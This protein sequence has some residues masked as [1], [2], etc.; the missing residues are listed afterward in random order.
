MRSRARILDESGNARFAPRPGVAGHRARSRRPTAWRPGTLVPATAI[1]RRLPC[2]R[3]DL[4]S[5][6]VGALRAAL[7]RL[8]L[9]R[10][11]LPVSR[12]K[13]ILEAALELFHERGYG[14]V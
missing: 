7:D 6:R 13:A 3:R 4:E 2:E 10:H 11:D 12:E 5:W 8:G 1:V 14:A 9:L